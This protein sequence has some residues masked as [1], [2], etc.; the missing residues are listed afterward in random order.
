MATLSVFLRGVND[1][2]EALEALFGRLVALGAKPYYLFQGDLAAG[3]SHFRVPVSRGLEI[4]GEL[5][6]RL[7]GL[8]LPRFA[9]DI[10]GGL[11]KAYLPEDINERTDAGWR[12][13][14]ASGAVGFYPVEA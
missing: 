13:K 11:G 3:T 6:Q 4:Y 10:P 1:C 2:P 14:A 8:E 12:L 7:S 9:V 5:R